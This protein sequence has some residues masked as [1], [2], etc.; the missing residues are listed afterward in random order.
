MIVLLL[1][2]ALEVSISANKL[3]QKYKNKSI[4]LFES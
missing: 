2:Q 1:E 3:A 4:C